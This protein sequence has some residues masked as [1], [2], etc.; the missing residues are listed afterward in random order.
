ME[1]RTAGRLGTALSALGHGMWGLAGWKD[2]DDAE[3]GRALDESVASGV[4]FFDTAFAYGDGRSESI[5]GGLVRARP[6]RKLFTASKLPPKNRQWP[7][8]AIVIACLAHL[9]S[10]R[11]LPVSF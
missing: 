4:T 10:S 2:T 9:I 3:V 8:A 11:R 5:L 7:A 1:L 6:G